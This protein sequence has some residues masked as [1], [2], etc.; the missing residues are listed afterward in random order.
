MTLNVEGVVYRGMGG[1]EFLGGSLG[2]ETPLLPFS[3]ADREMGI[4][5]TIVLS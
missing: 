3:S 2:F 4:L 5:G 1:E